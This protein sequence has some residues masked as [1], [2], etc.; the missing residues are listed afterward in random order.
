MFEY[1]YS[2]AG[3]ETLITI[4]KGDGPVN[5]KNNRWGKYKCEIHMPA[6]LKRGHVQERVLSTQEQNQN[7]IEHK[8]HLLIIMKIYVRKSSLSIFVRKSSL[9]IKGVHNR[10]W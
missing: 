6:P 7:I 10:I 9:S 5:E 8:H 4:D 2:M 1:W 3:F